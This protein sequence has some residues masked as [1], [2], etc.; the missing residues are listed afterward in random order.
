MFVTVLEN[1]MNDGKKQEN[2]AHSQRT[3]N[4]P[5]TGSDIIRLPKQRLLIDCLK[6]SQKIETR[7]M[8]LTDRKQQ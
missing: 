6:H 3:T 2:R 8:I 4:Y 7:R 1:I 5:Q